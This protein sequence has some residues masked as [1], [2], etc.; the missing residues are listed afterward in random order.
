MRYFLPNAV[1]VYPRGCLNPEKQSF[2][3]CLTTESVMQYIS[4]MPRR[5]PFADKRK[6]LKGV[7]PKQAAKQIKRKA[8]RDRRRLPK[9]S[10]ELKE[11]KQEL[12]RTQRAVE[13]QKE[14]QAHLNELMANAPSPAQQ[15]KVILG[16][17]H[18][19]GINPIQMMFDSFPKDENGQPYAESKEDRAMLR[20]LAG[21]FAPK[22]KS[23]DLTATS[24]A[25]VTIQTVDFANTT[26][27]DLKAMAAEEASSVMEAEVLDPANPD[28]DI[29]AEFIAPEAAQTVTPNPGGTL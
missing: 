21:Y 3:S 26:Q 5:D 2:F 9:A 14:I 7:K 4:S 27:K 12:A 10:Q 20:D 22:P 13:K 23:I 18:E 24:Q 8:C 25:S 19:A 1:E 28:G 16:M 17:F 15:R 29:Y 6:T 11:T